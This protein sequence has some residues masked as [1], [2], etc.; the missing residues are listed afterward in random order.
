MY[1]CF[2]D[3]QKAYDSIRRDSLKHKLEQLG[4]KGNFLDIITWIYS[5][6]KVSLSY[7]SYVS[8]PFSTPIGLKQGDILSTMFFTLF[9]NDLPTLL[10]KHS[11]QSEESESPELF[12]TQIS[13]LHFA[14]DLAIFSL[15]KNWLQEK[16]DFL[17]KYCRQW[18]LSLNLKKT[19]AI[20]FNK[21]GNTIKKFKF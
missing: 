10:E 6:T 16:L 3:F 15:T 18:D 1:T 21:Q 8:T 19:K 20:I 13:S 2:V 5:S 14:D 11:T 17:E 7:N 4:I 12:N 9:I